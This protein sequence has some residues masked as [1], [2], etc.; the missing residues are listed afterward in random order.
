MVVEVFLVVD[1]AATRSLAETPETLSSVRHHGLFTRAQKEKPTW[2]A[3]ASEG[4]AKAKKGRFW[5]LLHLFLS[6]NSFRENGHESICK[7]EIKNF[8]FEALTSSTVTLFPGFRMPSAHLHGL[9]VVPARH[10]KPP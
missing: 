8:P 4:N 9:T 3:A 7:N 10:L 6:P 5:K 2:M 1:V